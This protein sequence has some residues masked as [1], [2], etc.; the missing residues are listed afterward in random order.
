M[1]GSVVELLFEGFD[2]LG[3]LQNTASAWLLVL[4]VLRVGIHGPFLAE[5]AA[6]SVRFHLG[7]LDVVG[8]E[9]PGFIGVA[10]LLLGRQLH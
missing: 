5:H 2:L 10:V 7:Q 1:L 9:L 3:A 6:G 4:L 8:A